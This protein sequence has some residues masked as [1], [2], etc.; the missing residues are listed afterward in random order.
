MPFMDL[1]SIRETSEAHSAMTRRKVQESHG[2]C[3]RESQD[4]SVG[5]V[6][7]YVQLSIRLQRPVR[8]FCCSSKNGE[9]LESNVVNLGFE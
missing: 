3:F 5:V 8:T 1:R 4:S 7:W 2:N 6:E 9:K